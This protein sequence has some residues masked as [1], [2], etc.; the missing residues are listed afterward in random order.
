MEHFISAPD[1]FPA[2]FPVSKLPDL[3]TEISSKYIWSSFSDDRPSKMLI[4]FEK[5]ANEGFG[6]EYAISAPDAFPAVSVSKL[7]IS[8]QRFPVKIFCLRFSER[9][10]KAV[11]PV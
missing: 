5:I 1:P 2:I 3:H 10:F 9:P 11:V 8:T 6:F 4:S 7:Q